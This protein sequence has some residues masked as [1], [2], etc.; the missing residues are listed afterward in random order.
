MYGEL[1]TNQE[2]VWAG[3]RDFVHGDL[4]ITWS[5]AVN[6]V[7]HIYTFLALLP[8][9]GT[10]DVSN[11]DHHHAVVPVL[12]HPVQMIPHTVSNY[13]LFTPFGAASASM[14]TWCVLIA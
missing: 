7:V 9:I 4:E 13:Y 1:I 2:S 11:N 10:I 12:F 5:S 8:I 3:R 14:Y 6:L